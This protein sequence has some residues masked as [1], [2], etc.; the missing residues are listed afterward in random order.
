M[1]LIAAGANQLHPLPLPSLPTPTPFAV[2]A[3]LVRRQTAALVAFWLDY[4]ESLVHARGAVLVRPV[5]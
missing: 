1:S 5:P 3:R 2:F 4:A